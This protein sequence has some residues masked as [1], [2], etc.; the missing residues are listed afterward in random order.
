MANPAGG[1]ALTGEPSG[2]ARLCLLL[3]GFAMDAL[4]AEQ[5]LSRPSALAERW[6]GDVEAVIVLA[7][8][9]RA[10]AL[11][12]PDLS[13]L[14]EPL[15]CLA[16]VAAS[17]PF[18]GWLLQD[19]GFYCAECL[20]AQEFQE[21]LRLGDAGLERPG[22]S[23]PLDLQTE[24]T[25]DLAPYR[26]PVRLA[27]LQAALFEDELFLG[28]IL[29]GQPGPVQQ[30]RGRSW[31]PWP[32]KPSAPAFAVAAMRD[33]SAVVPLGG[34]AALEDAVRAFCAHAAD[35]E[36][37]VSPAG[38]EVLAADLCDVLLMPA[39]RA[40]G[41]RAEKVHRIT[42]AP[43]GVLNS[44]PFDLLV[45]ERRN[46]GEWREMAWLGRR[47][48]VSVTPSATVLTDIRAGAIAAGTRGSA[49]VG[50]GDPTYVRP[51]DEEQLTAAG[52]GSPSGLRGSEGGAQPLP[53]LPGSRHEIESISH[54]F[55]SAGVSEDD[56]LIFLS[57]AAA[58]ANLT[59]ELLGRAAYLHLACH[60]TAGQGTYLDGALFLAD[61]KHG[62]D[63]GV[64]TAREITG[65][66]TGAR[67][68][69]MSACETARGALSRGEGL[70][71]M[72]RAWLFA[73]AE[74][75]IASLWEVDDDSTAR[76]M[77]MFYRRLLAGAS[78]REAL[79]AAKRLLMDDPRWGHP[80]YW[81]AF[82][83]FADAE[84]RRAPVRMVATLSKAS[85]ASGPA[86]VNEE[87]RR[88]VLDA[89]S[90]CANAWES[91]RAGKAASFTDF[92]AGAQGLGGLDARHA[93]A[94]ALL[95]CVVHACAMARQVELGAGRIASAV[96]A[97][98]TQLALHTSTRRAEWDILASAYS[99]ECLARVRTLA[100]AG[101]LRRD[102]VF[103]I[104][105]DFQATLETTTSWLTAASG[106]ERDKDD[107]LIS[108]PFE[109]QGFT[110]NVAGAVACREA[111][112]LVFPLGPSQQVTVTE[113]L[114]KALRVMPGS[115]DDVRLHATAWGSVRYPTSLTFLLAKDLAPVR[116]QL[117]AVRGPLP[118]GWIVA[119]SDGLRI[120]I[121]QDSVGPWLARFAVMLRHVPGAGAFLA[122]QDQPFAAGMTLAQYGAIFAK[123]AG[124]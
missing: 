36:D 38:L 59:P 121:G 3:A 39:L 34:T 65:L 118:S 116:T 28:F 107:L 100:A 35:A 70:Q 5:R 93:D 61:A 18:Q 46:P 44:L 82:V 37:D 69:V 64:L 117:E 53:S 67:L 11:E 48:A 20:R 63:G 47:R 21:Q 111:R 71:G 105:S 6:I 76:L 87:P 33:W 102:F 19:I 55:Q 51:R 2:D 60:G 12:V 62:D 81:A 113:R 110:C 30:L 98:K 73:G 17:S 124:P 56:V 86:G 90:A 10:T 7:F 15:R 88:E 119:S 103:R 68:V 104:A 29:T 95:T 26:L 23:S 92:L 8:G 112:Q 75:V 120:T 91:W 97:Y 58:K 9:E 16:A 57:D 85:L 115:P 77:E 74:S 24:A 27:E 4:Q 114:S 52:I 14:A 108:L 106:T 49:F 109:D 42:C 123:I 89:L 80:S 79:A 99:E 122:R 22:A 41:S 96:G 72:V 1:P 78:I 43:D 40:A 84:E 50:F 94:A 54:V 31:T 66:R 25:P 101:L 32:A 45:V 13:A 83:Q